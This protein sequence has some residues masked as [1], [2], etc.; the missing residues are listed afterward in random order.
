[1]CELPQL[2][3]ADIESF[4]W[5]LS[6]VAQS[7]ASLLAI[8]GMFIVY[9]LQLL[10]HQLDGHFRD[11]RLIYGRD[12]FGDINHTDATRMMRWSEL[13]P[14]IE[15]AMHKLQT[16][17]DTNASS[18]RKAESE[19]NKPNMLFFTKGVREYERKLS[20]LAQCLD[21]YRRLS[22][23][24]RAVSK[25]FFPPLYFGGVTIA[26]CFAGLWATVWIID[27]GRVVWA[28][29]IVLSCAL[30]SLAIIVRALRRCFLQ[31]RKAK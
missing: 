7:L 10:E 14:A 20:S 13:V 4:R 18:L 30:V 11:A 6:T 19:G 29:V 22:E 23:F 3:A 24:H 28:A 21:Q 15:D 17:R 9:R 31:Q 16:T 2:F 5:L 27:A 1:M 25:V 8:G 26:L 12:V